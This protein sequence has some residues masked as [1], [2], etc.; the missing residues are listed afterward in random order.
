MLEVRD[1]NG[2]LIRANDDWRSDQETQIIATGIPPTN[3]LEAA[4]IATIPAGGASYTAIV[5]GVGGTT[6]IALVEV[7]GLN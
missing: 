5:S 6:G 4:V 3:D 1:Q 2:A 7:Y